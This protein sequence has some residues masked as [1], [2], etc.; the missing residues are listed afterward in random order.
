MSRNELRSTLLS[1][2][3]LLQ[4]SLWLLIALAVGTWSTQLAG[5]NAPPTYQSPNAVNDSA[6]GSRA[7]PSAKKRV[8]SGWSVPRPKPAAAPTVS[9]T[10]TQRLAS[11]PPIAAN[12]D[13]RVE[14]ASHEEL[15]GSPPTN[16]GNRFEEPSGK[17]VPNPLPPMTSIA[18]PSAPG[19]T[20]MFPAERTVP[21][22][23]TGSHLGLQ[24]GETATERSLRLMSI[25][26]EIEQQNAELADQVTKLAA[27]L[28][29]KDTKLQSSTSQIMAAR[30]EMALAQ[31]E[32]QRLRKEM[33]DF[34]DKFRSAEQ[35]NASLMRSLSPLL[36][37]ILQS[38]DDQP[39]RE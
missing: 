35:E 38:D 7:T 13:S 28:K 37:Q 5:Q 16:L 2:T 22:Q 8:P 20:I 32:F 6:A 18:R 33:A 23:I 19:P 12:R 24:P 31:E 14:Q 30:K 25:I 1:L 21:P 26:A 27:E 9:S 39:A 11:A 10:R 4:P 29:A 17:Y 34:R 15:S 36:K 3:Q